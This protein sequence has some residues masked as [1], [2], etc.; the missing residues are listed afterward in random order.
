TASQ[1][2]RS[3]S[4]AGAASRA[5][6]IMS[7]GPTRSGDSRIGRVA[8]NDDTTVRISGRR[9]AG[10]VLWQKYRQKDPDARAARML[11]YSEN[12]LASRVQGA[13]SSSLFR[14]SIARRAYQPR[15]RSACGRWRRL[16]GLRERAFVLAHLR[17]AALRGDRREA[18]RG[19]GVV[20]EQIAPQVEDL[21]V[22]R[23][24]PS[25]RSPPDVPRG[26]GRLVLGRVEHA[27]HL[28]RVA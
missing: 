14:S 11:M 8:R 18:Q 22:R 3:G 4:S 16:A 10:A 26:A 7:F 28:R 25:V 1:P 17:L 2:A 5:R 12:Q 23:K 13:S 21:G 20:T 24:P 27:E 6:P 9:S 19:V 15:Q